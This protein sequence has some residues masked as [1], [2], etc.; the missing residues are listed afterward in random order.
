MARDSSRCRQSHDSESAAR[1][2]YVIVGLPRSGTT[3]IHKAIAGHPNASA[4]NDELRVSPF[5]DL[6]LS[7]FTFGHETPEE[8][9]AGHVAL[10]D[11][12]TSI[13]ASAETRAFGVKCCVSS[14]K[15]AELV[16]TSTMRTISGVK[17]IVVV[18]RDLVAQYASLLRARRSGAWHSWRHAD[19]PPVAQVHIRPLLFDRY[20]TN[21][22]DT[23]ARLQC[24]PAAYLVIFEELVVSKAD[25]FRRIFDFLDL[26]DI[27]ID[28][29]LGDKVSPLPEA[30]IDNY[31]EMSDRLASLVERHASGRLGLGTRLAVNM[32]DVASRGRRMLRR[33]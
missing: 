6:G 7:T 22:L 21:A 16:V 20:V 9:R 19:R 17:M 24:A 28:W 13:A 18:R 31:H 10:F 1:I 32:I 12:V 11:A 4:L 29:E 5:W 23:L 30:Y 33:S 26:P 2:R 15:E 14:P 25:G 8:R 3:L 27:P